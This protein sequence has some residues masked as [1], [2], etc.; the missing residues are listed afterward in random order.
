M[1]LSRRL[2]G[3][4]EKI[5]EILGKYNRCPARELNSGPSE[6]KEGMLTT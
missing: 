6:Y 1:A 4:T 5:T 3:G 2:R